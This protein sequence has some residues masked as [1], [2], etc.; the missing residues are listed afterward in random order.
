[1]K[2]RID[3]NASYKFLYIAIKH[4]YN[5]PEI[6]KDVIIDNIKT[7]YE[8]SNY[9]YMRIKKIYKHD[10]DII[11]PD[12]SFVKN[13]FYVTFTLGEHKYYRMP[14][15]RIVGLIF[16]SI[17]QKYIDAGYDVKELVVDHIADGFSENTYD[18][19]IWNL[20][21]LTHRENISKASK[22]GY[23][24]MYVHEFREKLDKM[25]LEGYDNPSIYNFCLKE[26]GYGK[27]EV[28]AQLQVRRRRLGKTLKEHYEHDPK[29]VKKIDKYIKEGFSNDDIM[30]ILDIHDDPVKKEEMRNLFRYR[31]SLLKKPANV[32]K[33][34]TNEQSAEIE[35]LFAK[36]MDVYDIIHYFNMD[37]LE[38]EDN[39]TYQ[40]IKETL[41][42]RRCIYRK[43]L[44]NN[45]L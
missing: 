8:I 38:Y 37:N 36:D 1:M 22:C 35:K 33:Y 31:R 19:S 25:I 27:D 29:F 44:K 42:S 30:N 5:K 4:K 16:I 12:Y 34:F 23:R 6:W 41:F 39:E 28:K 32:S 24:P 7:K 40:K 13:H 3:I 14:V 17:P 18:N 9:G 15:S 20:Q 11:K 26:Y 43:K 45:K 21:W 10:D 2:N